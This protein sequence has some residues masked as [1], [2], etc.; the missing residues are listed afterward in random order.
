MEVIT[1]NSALPV[2]VRAFTTTRVGGV[3]EGA[4][5]SLNLATHVT[6]SIDAV[7][8]NRRRLQIAQELPNPP[9]WL[10]QVHGI[11]VVE[12]QALCSSNIVDGDAFYTSRPGVVC[13][14][15]SADCLPIVLCDG[16]GREVAAV[17]AGW[18]GLLHGVIRSAVENF[19]APASQLHAWIG[20]G[21]SANAYV[22]D[23]AFRRR[24]LERNAT[25]DLAFQRRDSS[26]H[27]DLYAIAK[28]ELRDCG[29]PTVSRYEG[30]THSENTK[31]FSH[32][33]D[34]VTGRM[35]TVVWLEAGV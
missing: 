35:A 13:A 30:C 34:G 16:R 19:S 4:F 5:R 31:F 7:E 2:N 22:V 20:P 17:H 10:N 11:E 15:M 26:W 29:I 25:F 9:H 1:P 14:I 27:A 8:E 24:F 6:D 18:K 3:S 23:A 21:V 33:R 28:Q 32:R 12:A